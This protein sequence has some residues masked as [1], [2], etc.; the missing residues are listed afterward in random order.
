MGRDLTPKGPIEKYTDTFVNGASLAAGSGASGAI[1]TVFGTG[2]ATSSAAATTST[3]PTT[4]GGATVQVKD[5]AGTTQTC[6][7]FYA[8]PTQIN[9]LI[10]SGVA[11]GP[12]TFT[13]QTSGGSSAWTNVAI[14]TVAPGL[15]TA[16]ASGVG[17]GAITGVRVD[18]S[19]QQTAVGIFS[20]DSNVEAVRGRSHQPRRRHRFGL[21]FAL[22]HG[23][24][25]LQFARRNLGDHRR[26][27]RAGVGRGRAIAIRG[28]GPGEY[29]TAA[30][31]ARGEGHEQPRDDG[32]RHGRQLG[33]GEHPMKSACARLGFFWLVLCAAASAQTGAITTVAGNLKVIATGDG[34]QATSA[35]MS[36]SGIAVDSSGN[37]YIADGYNNRVRKVSSTGTVTTVAGNGTR[38]FS[39]DGQAATAAELNFPVAVAV[40]A[41]GNLF[42]A[43][44]YNNRIR[45]VSAG[46]TITTVAGNGAVNS[47]SG[48]G[49]YSGDNGPAISAGLNLPYG[50]AVD[51]SGNLFIADLYNNRVRKVNTAGTITTVAGNGQQGFSGDGAQATAAS[52]A[53]PYGIAVDPSGNLF[54]AD[55]GNDRVRKV[56]STGVIT[57]I[58]GNGNP[59]F[60][61]DGGQAAAAQLNYPKGLAADASGNLCIADFSS[62][63]IR[64][65]ATTGIITTIAGNG[66]FGFSGD[67]GPATA[68]EL[69]FPLG[70]AV[71]ASGNLFIADTNS[72]VRK[73]AASGSAGAPAPAIASGGIAPIASKVSTISA[74]EWVSI[75]GANLASGVA[76]WTGNFPTTLGGSSVTVDGKPA[77]LWYVSP[78][79]INLQVPDDSATGP[80]HGRR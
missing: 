2:M 55:Y 19:G 13:I 20:Y 12:A 70:V 38:G 23:N 43:D 26:R 1:M 14:G 52:L 3:L 66:N 30:A 80:V 49:T 75:Y 40:D 15:F 68:A 67:G 39:G 51:G 45:K 54:I 16:N 61:G 60:S 79:Q 64:K 37:F 58:A 4:L 47:Q 57:T 36:T 24:P 69:E 63:R 28:T 48:Q 11:A 21:P 34:G 62:S 72:V 25:R 6:P 78:S 9:L 31:F 32:G 56:S 22:R 50:V 8:S 10:P 29:R 76:T 27:Q 71:D 65:I 18:A 73:V 77:Y 46:G 59:A 53:Q 41:S 42:I 7:L 17:V 74:G 5:S 33:H 44:L 35:G